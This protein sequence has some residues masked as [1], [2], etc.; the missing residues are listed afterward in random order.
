MAF[1][2]TFSP[3]A[4][5]DI[6]EIVAYIGR[7]NRVAAERMVQRIMTRIDPLSFYPRLGKIAPDID[8][9]E[10]REILE[11][12]Y[13]IFYRVFEAERKISIFRI[14]HGSRR[15]PQI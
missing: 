11:T 3:L 14:W 2:I 9:E 12:P 13:R 15:P 1:K 7:D 4:E 6:E 5:Q 8:C 10:V